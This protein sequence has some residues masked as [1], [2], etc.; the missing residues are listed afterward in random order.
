MTKF[1]F[2]F[3]RLYFWPVFDPFPHF[4][5]AKKSIPKKIWHAQLNKVF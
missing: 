5:G 3:K 1:F 4:L 2:K